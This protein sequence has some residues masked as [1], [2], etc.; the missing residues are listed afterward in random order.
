MVPGDLQGATAT[1][2]TAPKI[3]VASPAA[4]ATRRHRCREAVRSIASAMAAMA[5][6]GGADRCGRIRARA[7]RSSR[8]ARSA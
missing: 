2:A 1:S 3:A 5:F 7:A 8:A 4:V 6:S